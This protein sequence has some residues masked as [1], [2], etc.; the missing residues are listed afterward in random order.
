V[1]AKNSRSEYNRE[2]GVHVEALIKTGGYKSIYDFWI[3]RAGDH[4]S[5][6][7]LNYLVAGRGDPKLSTLRIVAELLE[8][9]F[10]NI[11]PG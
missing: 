6:A 4:I 8:I 1:P 3:N 11:F 2:L 10:K 7:S 9:P 5:R